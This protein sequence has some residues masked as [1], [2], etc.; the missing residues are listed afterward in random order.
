[1][2][3]MNIEYTDID[4]RTY[5]DTAFAFFFLF[6]GGPISTTYYYE[7]FPSPVKI[8]KEISA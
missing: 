7:F 2:I 3:S 5:T 8:F 4:M 1:M 6:V